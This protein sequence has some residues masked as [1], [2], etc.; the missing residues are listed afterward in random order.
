MMLENM[1]ELEYNKVIKNKEISLKS[2]ILLKYIY[3][4]GHNFN[5]GITTESDL[6]EGIRSYCG[7]N[8]EKVDECITE[9][10][11]HFNFNEYNIGIIYIIFDGSAFKIGVTQNINKRLKSLQTSCSKKLEI[12]FSKE[13][14]NY[15][16]LELF[17]H[18]KY[19]DKRLSGEWFDLTTEDLNNITK[20]INESG[21]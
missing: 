7:F 4:S 13:V 5:Y 1:N 19:K 12:I 17:L 8:Q 9:L 10:G 11:E 14:I 15:T 21:V 3:T 20:I 18:D 2:R 16:K 6:Y